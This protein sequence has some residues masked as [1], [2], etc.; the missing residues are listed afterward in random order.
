VNAGETLLAALVSLTGK[1]NDMGE[2]LGTGM[3][4][5]Q[6]KKVA[7]HA[8]AGVRGIRDTIIAQMKS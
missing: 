3:Y 6:L 7:A 4:I 8:E 5:G 2:H 1:Y